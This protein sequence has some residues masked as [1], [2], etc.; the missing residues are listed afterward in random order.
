MKKL[1]MAAALLC[2]MCLTANAKS[3]QPITFEALP[4]IVQEEIQKN[5]QQTQIQFITSE[6]VLGHHA[7]SFA[8]DNGTQITYNEKAGLLEVS[9]KQGVDSVFVPEKIYDYIKRT[10]PNGTITEYKYESMKQEVELNNKL[11]LIFD[12]RGSFLRI[13][14]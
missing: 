1:F 8:I 9:N 10:F 3:K 5:F 11:D 2:L 14:D 13:D 12:K 6:K 7:Y 4:L